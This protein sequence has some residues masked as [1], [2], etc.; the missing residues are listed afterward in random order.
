MA[1]TKKTSNDSTE[2]P[3][4]VLAES[5]QW[6]LEQAAIQTPR[7]KARANDLAARIRAASAPKE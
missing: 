7:D 3:A 6:L 5:V 1:G 4:A 2:Q